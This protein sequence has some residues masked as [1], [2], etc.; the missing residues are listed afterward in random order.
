MAT[1]AAA[2]K[3]QLGDE[4]RDLRMNAKAL[5]ERSCHSSAN[6]PNLRRIKATVNAVVQTSGLTS[7]SAEGTAGAT[8]SCNTAR[9]RGDIVKCPVNCCISTNALSVPSPPIGP[10][11]TS[12]PD[13]LGISSH[14]SFISPIPSMLSS[15]SAA[16]TG[17]AAHSAC[18]CIA[19][20]A[21]CCSISAVGMWK[22]AA[23][24]GTRGD[25]RGGGAT[26]G[27]P[28]ST[29]P[30]AGAL[31]CRNEL[32]EVVA[33]LWP[34]LPAAPNAMSLSLPNAAGAA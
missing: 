34:L 21:A 11:A 10:P 26:P 25:G 14:S 1:S 24:I 17:S 6:S 20:M 18:S 4:R 22:S 15:S 19:A 31:A 33:P 5:E 13:I 7:P 3:V 16:P 8:G 30:A 27:T 12:P 2:D 9:R 28:P 23:P 29:P 32:V